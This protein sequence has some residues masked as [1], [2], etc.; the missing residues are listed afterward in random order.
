MLVLPAHS[1]D[2]ASKWLLCTCFPAYVYCVH[3]KC[4]ALSPQQPYKPSH[5]QNGIWNTRTREHTFP[6]SRFCSNLSEVFPDQRVL[7]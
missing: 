6:F 2:L 5:L 3:F 4:Q 1:A 7:N